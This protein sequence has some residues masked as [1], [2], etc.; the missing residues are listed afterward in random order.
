MRIFVTGGTGLIGRRL[1]PVLIHAGHQVVLL[2]R[3]PQPNLSRGQEIIVGDPNQPHDSWMNLLDDCQGV[4]HLAGAPLFTKRWTK[5]FK[6]EIRRS[7]VSST[8]WIATRLLQKPLDNRVFLSGSAI[9]YYGN[10][11]D[12]ELNENSAPG[13]GFLA[14]VSREWEDAA[15]QARQVARVVNIRTGIVL[16]PNGGSLPKMKL[17]FKLFAGGPLGNGQ[18]WMSWIHHEDMVR[19]IVFALNEAQMQGPVNFTAPE[20]VRNWGFC[21]TLGS[22]MK[23]PSWLPAPKFAIKLALG[24]VAEVALGSQRVYPARLSDMNFTFQYPTLQPALENLLK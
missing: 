24:E 19:G 1:I 11:G 12:E 9:G 21:K 5:R 17:P 2:T 16:D 18:Q 13:Q 23:R 10:R 8:H 22:V 3:S 20:P 15:E 6:E 7:R 14:D 4:I